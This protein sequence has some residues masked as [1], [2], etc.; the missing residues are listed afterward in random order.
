MSPLHV[1]FINIDYVSRFMVCNMNFYLH[2]KQSSRPLV[3]FATVF[4]EDWC[5]RL[6]HFQCQMSKSWYLKWNENDIFWSIETFA[7]AK[8]QM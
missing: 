5:A 1:A 2:K 4:V 8:N 3:P 7:M 6:L